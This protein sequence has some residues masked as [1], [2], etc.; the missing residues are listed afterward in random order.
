MPNSDPSAVQGASPEHTSG[1][2]TFAGACAFVLARL[3]GDNTSF[4]VDVQRRRPER[5]AGPQ[6]FPSFG[7]AADVAANGR[8]CNGIH[9]RFAGEAALGVGRRIGR[10]VSDELEVTRLT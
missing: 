7:I 3:F 8:I 1:T 5:D 9:F 6:E 2:A 10:L 4:T